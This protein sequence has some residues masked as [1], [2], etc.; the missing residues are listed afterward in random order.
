MSECVNWKLI[1]PNFQ[2]GDVITPFES[3]FEEQRRADYILDGGANH[4]DILESCSS[5]R[6]KNSQKEGVYNQNGKQIIPEEFDKCELIIYNSG[7]FYVTA[8]QV[9]KE[10]L[11]GLYES[12]GRMIVPAEFIEINVSDYFVVV[13][14][15]NGLY[16]AY[17]FNGKK[18]IDCE[19]NCI[20]ATGS[21]DN[22]FGYAIVRKNSLVGVIS[23]TGDEIVP[24][25][26]HGIYKDICNQGYR[27]YN[28]TSE[29]T[30]LHG[31]YS[32]NGKSNIPCLFEEN[33]EFKYKEIYVETPEGL[34]GIYSYDGIEIVPPKFKSIHLVGDYFVGLIENNELSLYDQNGNCLYSTTN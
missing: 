6:R 20:D 9:Q 4:H 30:I 28:K 23:E 3:E 1:I 31:W 26:F 2:E 32:R 7:D 18:I 14:D 29:G 15:K 24:V 13:K 17:L 34:K 21:L 11:Y 10:G 27:V 25:K 8:I 12:N 33:F 5:I 19:Y 22:G 16:G